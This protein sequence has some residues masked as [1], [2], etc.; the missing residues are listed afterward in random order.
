M[1]FNFKRRMDKVEGVLVTQNFE[2]ARQRST[3]CMN[4]K[5]A[6]ATQI[7]GTLAFFATEVASERN[8]L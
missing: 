5:N 3:S 2:S 8:P 7:G 4:P 1:E 6:W